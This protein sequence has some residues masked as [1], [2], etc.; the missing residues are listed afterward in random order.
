M[1]QRKPAEVREQEEHK[2]DR[3]DTGRNPDRD[4][5]RGRERNR[6]EQRERERDSLAS[7]QAISK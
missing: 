3:P 4:P 2:S 5:F 1:P 7:F 6:E